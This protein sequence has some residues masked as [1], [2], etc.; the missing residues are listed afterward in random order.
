[1]VLK[2]EIPEKMRDGLVSPCPLRA[3]FLSVIS[4]LADIISLKHAIWE[5]KSVPLYLG[6]VSPF[7]VLSRR[8]PRFA[9]LSSGE[10]C[11]HMDLGPN[12]CYSTIQNR[13]SH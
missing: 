5:Q 2:E 12:Q 4:L 10:S 9:F 13:P 6:G 7:V 8:Q 1:M 11:Q 3:G